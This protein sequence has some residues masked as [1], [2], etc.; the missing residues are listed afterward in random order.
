MGL[1]QEY[2]HVHGHALGGLVAASAEARWGG[3]QPRRICLPFLMPLQSCYSSPQ[4]RQV[5]ESA[6]AEEASVC[7]L[8]QQEG[9]RSGR[10]LTE[11]P[12]LPH[13]PRAGPY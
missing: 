3:Q 4:R 1:A 11:G 6:S 12:G 7:S 9:D 2:C 10:K 5:E 13:R 8:Q